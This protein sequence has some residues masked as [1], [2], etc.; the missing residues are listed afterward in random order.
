MSDNAHSSR[1]LGL[2]ALAVLACCGAKVL[3]VGGL[4]L[5]VG[6]VGVVARNVALGVAG[7]AVAAALVASGL[8]RRRRCEDV[9]ETLVDGSA[10][11]AEGDVARTATGGRSA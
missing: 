10:G 9:C 4:A 6:S 8:R 7:L 1:G 2:A 11:R 3:V 5:S